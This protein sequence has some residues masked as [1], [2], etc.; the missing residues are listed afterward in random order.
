[1][2]YMIVL[3]ICKDDLED[4][5]LSDFIVDLDINL[6]SIIKECGNRCLVINNK[7]ERV[8]RE[9]QV[10]ELMGFVEILVQNN[11][12]FYFFYFVYKDAERRLKK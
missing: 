3:F 1:M 8:E 12:G 2:K 6:K 5:S 7:V 4:Q 9:T 11:G 10:Q